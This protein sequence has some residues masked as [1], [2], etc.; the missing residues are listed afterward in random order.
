[1]RRLDQVYD[2]NRQ[3]KNKYMPALYIDP[4]PVTRKSKT[5]R[6][7]SMEYQGHQH[8]NNCIAGHIVAVETSSPS[9]HKNSRNKLELCAY[10]F[11][12]D[13]EKACNVAVFAFCAIDTG[14]ALA[15]A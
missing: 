5:S 1:M 10:S 13:A 15:L 9:M 4:E 12:S 7:E 2:K 8:V 11:I 3:P 6:V 14:I